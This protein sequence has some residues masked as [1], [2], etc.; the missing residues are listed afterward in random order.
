MGFLE[1]MHLG[2]NAEA[3]PSPRAT[4]AAV[5]RQSV[6]DSHVQVGGCSPRRRSCWQA[7]AYV[8][9]ISCHVANGGGILS[10]GTAYSQLGCSTHH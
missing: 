6:V 4:W 8:H 5:L 9:V 1:G 7:V 10:A 3:G 2:L